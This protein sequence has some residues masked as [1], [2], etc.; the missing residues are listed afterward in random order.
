MTLE[1]DGVARL[2]ECAP[3]VSMGETPPA[4]ACTPLPTRD[5]V[6]APQEVVPLAAAPR[7]DALD[8]NNSARI[9]AGPS[10]RRLGRQLGADLARVT[11]SGR[12]GRILI[13]D[14]HKSVRDELQAA[15]SRSAAGA[16]QAVPFAALKIDFTKYGEIERA[17]L[18]RIRRISGTT[19][20]RNWAT[21]SLEAHGL[22]PLAMRLKSP[23]WVWRERPCSLAGTSINFCRA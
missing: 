7:S 18:S 22:L 14:V 1:A 13:E 20:A 3:A 6:A 5:T 21:I 11:G 2:S 10:V 15:E 19:L 23:F 17:P 12:G 16:P 9:Y 8:A 4:V